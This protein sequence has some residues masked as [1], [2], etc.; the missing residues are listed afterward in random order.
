MVP[1]FCVCAAKAQSGLKTPSPLAGRGGVNVCA[2]TVLYRCGPVLVSASISALPG[3][4]R[5]PQQT[6][7]K[8]EE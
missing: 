6:L 4:R 8:V 2:T 5:K 3:E 7:V 1:V